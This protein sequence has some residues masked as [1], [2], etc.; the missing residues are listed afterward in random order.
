MKPSTRQTDE[1]ASHTQDSYRGYRGIRSEMRTT[2]HEPRNTEH[3]TQIAE[4]KI[5]PSGVRGLAKSSFHYLIKVF[6]SFTVSNPA[7]F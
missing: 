4:P 2:N 3:E 5:S 7:I 1:K 6:S